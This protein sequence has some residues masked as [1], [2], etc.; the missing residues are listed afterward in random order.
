MSSFCLTVSNLGQDLRFGNILMQQWKLHIYHQEHTQIMTI[1]INARRKWLL[2]H[3]VEIDDSD[4]LEEGDDEQWHWAHVAVEDLQPVVP[5]AQGEHQ[6]HQ[7]GDQANTS[8]ESWEKTW[9]I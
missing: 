5:W 6:G 9:S 1:T 8:F 7:E 4:Q 3:P 2:L